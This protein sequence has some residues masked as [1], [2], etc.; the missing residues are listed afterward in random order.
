MA[1]IT[2]TPLYMD[3]VWGGRELE[4]VYGRALPDTTTPF[5]EAWEIVDRDPEQSVVNFGAYAGKS[6]HE[7]WTQHREKIFGAGLPGSERFPILIKILDSRDDLS[8]QVHPPVHL[9]AELGGEPKTEMWVIA[10]ADAGAKLYVGLRNGVTRGHF[11]TAIAHGTVAEVV[12]AIAPQVG[13]SI[14]IPSGRLHA[15]GAG[16]LIHEIQQNSDT[17]YRV[18]DWNRMGLDGKPR[19]LHVEQSLASIDFEDFEPGMDVPQ[20]EVLAECEYF[21][22]SRRALVDGDLIA[23]PD[24]ERFSIVGV[25]EGALVSTDNRRFVKGDYILQPKGAPPLVAEGDAVVLQVEMPK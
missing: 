3:R 22:T 5:G 17:T 11:E 2:F 21:R 14:F 24:P 8:I 13:E 16:L 18:F 23:N 4:R 15:I 20:G 25:V 7:L 19:A 12:H 1:P 6:L 9:A 10:A